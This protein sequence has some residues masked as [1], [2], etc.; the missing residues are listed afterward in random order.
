MAINSLRL[1]LT[2]QVSDALLVSSR[3]QYDTTNFIR[4]LSPQLASLFLIDSPHRKFLASL[5]AML[6]VY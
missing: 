3:M 5:R 1:D 4:A 2:I 6:H